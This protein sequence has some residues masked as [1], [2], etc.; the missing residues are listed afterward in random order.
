MFQIP[1]LTCDCY[2]F[3]PQNGLDQLY[4]MREFLVAE[5]TNSRSEDLLASLHG[6][7]LDNWFSTAGMLAKYIIYPDK[8]S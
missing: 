4:W 1:Q 3:I 2:K 8:L 7:K 6:L 5:L